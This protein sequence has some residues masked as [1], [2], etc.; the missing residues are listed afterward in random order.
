[1]G[2]KGK[3][4]KRREANFKASHPDAVARL[5]PPPATKDISAVPSKLRRIMQFR[6]AG[7]AGNV[8]AGADVGHSKKQAKE[9]RESKHA[10]EETKNSKAKK[11]EAP[12]TSVSNSGKQATADGQVAG[13]NTKPLNKRRREHEELLQ[14]AEKIKANPVRT[15]LSDR[16]KKYLEEKK[17]KRLKNTTVQALLNEPKRDHVA[18]GDIVQA[19]PELA[20]PAKDKVTMKEAKP[21][22]I[23]RVRLQV[24]EAYRQRK[25]TKAGLAK[26]LPVLVPNSD[27]T[28]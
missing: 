15:V 2:N 7:V 22:S 3:G 18:F 10:K 26:G 12:G 24:I 25:G 6:E 14:L 16:E 4:R 8:N 20:F 9:S 27:D 13:S 1:M 23:E 17:K 11:E 5:A 19:P 28:T 21:A